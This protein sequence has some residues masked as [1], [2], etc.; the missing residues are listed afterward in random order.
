MDRGHVVRDELPTGFAPTATGFVFNLGRE[1]LQDKRVREAIALAWNFE[2]TNE[3]LQY[4]LFNQRASFAQGTE[5]QADGPPEGLE[6]EL[7]ESLGDLVPEEILTEPAR[8]PHTSSIERLS[9][10]RNL[11]QAR[12]LL[13]EAGWEVDD[14]GELRNE[15][16]ERMRIEI[17]VSSAGSAT[18][19]SITET[20]V[21]NLQSLGIDARFQRIDAAQHTDRRRNRD[22]DIIFDQYAAFMDTG[23]GLHQRF[24]SEAADISLFNPAGLS[25]DLVDAV[26][27]ASLMAPTPDDRDAALMALDR[28]LRHEMF[29]IPAWYNDSVWIAHWD[30]FQRPEDTPPFA[31]GE[32]DFWWFDQD[33]FDELRASGALR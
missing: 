29:I 5:F 18:M 21:Q 27:D 26:I 20:F 6:L 12:M 25:S 8:M 22:Y 31:T 3:T 13:E 2:W 1:F 33:R 30:I 4:G 9:D 7:L 24:G 19:D 17:P 14:A 23:T 10:R 15:A 28:V 11:R 32:M 16:G